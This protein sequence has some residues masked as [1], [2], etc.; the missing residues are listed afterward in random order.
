VHT[1]SGSGTYVEPDAGMVIIHPLTYHTPPKFVMPDYSATAVKNSKIPDPRTTIFW[2]GKLLTDQDG[3]AQVKFFTADDNSIY[4]VTVTG[5][6]QN[7]D[8]I[9]KRITINRK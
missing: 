1:K 3:K 5:V 9:Y 2:N 8:Y 4:T 6:T 7:G